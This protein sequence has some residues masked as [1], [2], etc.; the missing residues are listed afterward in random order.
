MVA[1]EQFKRE[2]INSTAA[3]EAYS[4]YLEGISWDYFITVTFKNDF[5]DSIRAHQTVWETLTAHHV[6][7]AFLATERH[8]YPNYACHVH[9]LVKV[10][11]FPG[12]DDRRFYHE[13]ERIWLSL[14]S[15]HGRSRVEEIREASQVAS[16]CSKYVVKRLSDYGFY[17]EPSFW[18]GT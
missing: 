10:P 18:T 13:P 7:R 14:F 3:R 16:Y 17:G 8:R 1:Y 5:R 12:S 15:N 6:E 11:G 4:K 2:A 9:G